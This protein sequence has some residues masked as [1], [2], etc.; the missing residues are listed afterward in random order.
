MPMYLGIYGFGPTNVITTRV[1]RMY[2]DVSKEGSHYM[3][4][5]ENGVFEVSNGIILGMWNA[6]QIYARLKE[7]K[8]YT[9]TTKGECVANFFL[10]QYPYVLDAVENN[11][12]EVGNA[13]PHPEDPG[14]KRP[15]KGREGWR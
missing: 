6:D 10:Q 2:V 4:G 5:T 7:G 11:E 1:T 9:F 13:R 3:V 12:P 8:S 14:G 15:P